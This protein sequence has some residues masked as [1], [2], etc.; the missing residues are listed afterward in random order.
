MIN[1]RI[2]LSA[3]SIAAAGA[4]VIG[5]TFA[6]FSDSGT[7]S[8]NSF[9]TGTLD[10]K[11]SD[12]TSETDQDSVT[13]SFGGTLVPGGCT[14]NQQ[15]RLK[16]SG[17]VNAN[18]AEV[19][20]TSN[21]VTDTGNNASPDIDTFLRI[22]LLTYDGGDVTGQLS[23]TNSNVFLDLA[24]WAA[25]PAALDNLSLTDL[26]ANHPLVMDVC[27][28]SNAGNTLQGDSVVSTFTVDLNQH[29]SQ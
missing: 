23:D 12:D 28:D 22:N 26:S 5:A 1:S 19:R 17:T 21:V 6:Y 15:L 2:L 13:A 10:L 11:L 25:T 20:L 18:H 4:L 14:G 16:N 3:A 29:S 24:D 8:N 27:L 7:S 9:S